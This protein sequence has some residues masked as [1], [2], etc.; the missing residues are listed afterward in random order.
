MY[1][2]VH[3]AQEAEQHQHGQQ[4]GQTAGHGVKAM[5]LLQLHH[6]F[7]L[8]LGVVFVLLLDLVHQRLEHRHLG[9][10]FLL[11]DS[12]REQQQLEDQGGND[13]GCRV[14]A[15]EVVQN[16]HQ[17][18]NQDGQEVEKLHS[19]SILPRLRPEAFILT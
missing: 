4:H 11:V 12:Q 15:D 8:L 1:R 19:L 16:L 18:A 5:F 14:V 6:F 2:V 7:L 17:R 13:H 3:H 9:G 10:G